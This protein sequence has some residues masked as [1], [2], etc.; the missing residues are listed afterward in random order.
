MYEDRWH[1]SDS[2]PIACQA[3]SDLW[4]EKRFCSSNQTATQAQPDDALMMAASIILSTPR[5]PSLAGDAAAVQ[6]WRDEIMQLRSLHGAPAQKF[7]QVFTSVFAEARYLAEHCARSAFDGGMTVAPGAVSR[8]FV[9]DDAIPGHLRAA[10]AAYVQDLESAPGYKFNWHPNGNG[11]LLDL[12]HPAMFSVEYGRTPIARHSDRVGSTAML[13]LHLLASRMRPADEPFL[14]RLPLLELSSQK[15]QWLPTEVRV[16]SN[17]SVS[18]L[19][20]INGLNP[21]WHRQLYVLVAKVFERFVPLLEGL[22]GLVGSDFVRLSSHSGQS[23]NTSKAGPLSFVPP[24]KPPTPISLRGR[25]L[26]LFVKLTTVHLTPDRP[27]YAAGAWHNEGRSNEAIVAS[28][29]CYYDSENVTDAKLFF[30]PLNS[31][32]FFSYHP[33]DMPDDQWMA[34]PKGRC[35]AFSNMLRHRVGNFELVDPKKPGFRRILVFFLVD[36]AKRIVSTA[37]VAPQQAWWYHV[38]LA[39]TPLPPELWQDVVKHVDGTMSV[40]RARELRF[41]AFP[42][43]PRATTALFR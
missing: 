18:I 30:R 14:T 10:L 37:H 6:R 9:S 21:V 34:T 16:E 1:L 39:L 41:E 17:G 23:Q 19:S 27:Q 40:D 38:G 25:N 28:G 36:P 24:N 35:I 43:L 8:T 42:P 2:S 26:Q 11:Q 12:V 7:D 15:T 33:S 13:P 29:I 4:Q 31:P 22:S 32:S 5:W 20:P 3:N